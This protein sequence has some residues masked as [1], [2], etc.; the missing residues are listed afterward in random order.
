M[1]DPKIL[2][3]LGYFYPQLHVQLGGDLRG[4]G[5]KVQDGWFGGFY[6]I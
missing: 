4:V 3:M 6:G 2:K 5:A 1:M